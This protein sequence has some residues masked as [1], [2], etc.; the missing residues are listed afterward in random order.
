MSCPPSA[1]YEAPAAAP[2][3]A[4]ARSLGGDPGSARPS[5]AGWTPIA[6]EAERATR[7][8]HP[9]DRLPRPAHRRVLAV[10]NQ[11]GGVGKTT[12]T[13]N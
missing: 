4:S 3:G 10:A 5:D 11:K 7:V 6:D 13:V 1:P 2:A 8:K 12:S 9:T